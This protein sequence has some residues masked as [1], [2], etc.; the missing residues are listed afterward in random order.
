MLRC[1]DLL[2]G[3]PLDVRVVELALVQL[4]ALVRLTLLRDQDAAEALALLAYR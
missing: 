3:G 4:A 2:L 1:K